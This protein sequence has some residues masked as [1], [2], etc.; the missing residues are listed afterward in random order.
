VILL[1]EPTAHLDEPTAA[2]MMADVRAATSERI[3]VLVTHRQV[4]RREDDVIVELGDG[5]RDAVDARVEP[6]LR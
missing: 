5:I 1:D 6:V 4:G 3:V 2:A